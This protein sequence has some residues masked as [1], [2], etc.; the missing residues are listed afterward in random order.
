M[1]NITLFGSKICVFKVKNMR[2]S[3]RERGKSTVRGQIKPL[4]E[5]LVVHSETY[6]FASLYN[7]CIQ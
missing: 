5:T 2:L 6:N 4:F 1:Q 3:C 7:F